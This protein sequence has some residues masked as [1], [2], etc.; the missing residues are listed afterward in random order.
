MKTI[1]FSI[2]IAVPL[3]AAL[4]QAASAAGMDKAT[5]E[6]LNEQQLEYLRRSVRACETA[7]TGVGGTQ[8]C[9]ISDV[10]GS[11]NESN[12]AALKSFHESLP[13]NVRYNED[14]SLTDVERVMPSAH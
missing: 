14:R 13:V 2:C 9:V 6:K 8:A 10:D 5:L 3:M 11:I 7:G 1:F 4:P 12:D